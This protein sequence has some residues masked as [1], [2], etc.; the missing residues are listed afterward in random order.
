VRLS[1]CGVRGRALRVDYEELRSYG[2]VAYCW[3]RE[4]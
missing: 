1:R 4:Y 3:G 2:E